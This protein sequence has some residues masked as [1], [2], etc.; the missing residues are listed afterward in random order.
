MPCLEMSLAYKLRAWAKSPSSLNS[1]FG[2]VLVGVSKG[3]QTVAYLE[4]SPEKKDD[5]RSHH[6]MNSMVETNSLV[7]IHVGESSETRAS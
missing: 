3:H 1:V 4:G 5:I 2:W 7:G 6:K